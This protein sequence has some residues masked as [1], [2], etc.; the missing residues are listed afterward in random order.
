MRDHPLRDGIFSTKL[1]TIIYQSAAE[2][3]MKDVADTCAPTP[4]RNTTNISYLKHAYFAI[5][6]E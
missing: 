4:E 1:I 3:F 5:G 6:N 2:G